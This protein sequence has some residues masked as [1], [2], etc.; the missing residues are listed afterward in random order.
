VTLAAGT[1]GPPARS[2]PDAAA[3][4]AGGEAV[5]SR[6]LVDE[7][8]GVLGGA[9]HEARFIVDEVL[10]VGPGGARSSVVPAGAAA[11]AR[12]MAA[13]RAAGEPL[14]YIFGHWPFRGLDLRVDPRALIPRPETEQVVEVALGE[15]RRVRRLRPEKELV[16]VD[17]GT[18]S[19]AIALALAVELGAGVMEEIWA[20]DT[21][22]GALRVAAANLEA[23]VAAAG[24]G[25][26]PP[27]ALVEG[28]WLD[29][30]PHRLRGRVDL[31]VSNPPYVTE[32]EWAVLAP[33]VRAEPRQALVAGPGRQ[34]AAGLAD[35][36]A[37]LEEARRWLSRPGAVVVE[38]APAQAGAAAD[39]ARQLGYDEVRVEPD[40]AGRP[41]ALVARRSGSE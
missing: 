21:S 35:V 5:E 12:A 29:P 31:V 24:S 34:G 13:R 41:R 36:E 18:G 6:V 19:G 17:A 32:E 15:A 2:A 37:V 27:V 39:R 23:C 20:T 9:R 3:A 16:A 14:Q 22:A 10:H 11:E 33:E 26:L 4:A 38:L 30:L 1:A 25:P 40:L 8:A 28:S 7:L